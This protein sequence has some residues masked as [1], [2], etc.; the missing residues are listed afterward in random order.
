M[1]YDNDILERMNMGNKQAIFYS[2]TADA[3]A[4][5]IVTGMKSV[6]AVAMTPKSMASAPGLTRM[7]EGVAGTATAGTVAVTGVASGDTFYLMVFG[8]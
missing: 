6:D 2:C 3:A 7:N 5:T 4:G 1:A 8:H